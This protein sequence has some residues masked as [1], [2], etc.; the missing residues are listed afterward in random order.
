[1]GACCELKCD[2]KFHIKLS[3]YTTLCLFRPCYDS[4]TQ[5]KYSMTRFYGNLVFIC[6]QWNMRIA[7]FM[8]ICQSALSWY[9]TPAN[10]WG[11]IQLQLWKWFLTIV[12][13]C[14]S[15]KHFNLLHFDKY[16][17][18]NLHNFPVWINFLKCLSKH[19]EFQCQWIHEARHIYVMCFCMNGH[20]PFWF[21]GFLIL[22]FF[23]V[24]FTQNQLAGMKIVVTQ[25]YQMYWVPVW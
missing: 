4:T 18:I 12:L 13:N 7:S 1:M 19:N 2:L 6:I 25:S 8:L 10:R 15:G 24:L 23:V 16:V 17:I 5:Y 14:T 22:F 20:I 21:S 9:D 11:Q 3:P